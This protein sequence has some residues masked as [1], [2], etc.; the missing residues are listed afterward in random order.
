MYGSNL[1]RGMSK[2]CGCYQSDKAREQHIVHGEYGTP[3]YNI[4]AG[5][6]QRCYYDKH[7]DNIWYSSK[8]ITVCDE[9]RHDFSA[10][11]DWALSSGYER[12]LS[13]DRISNDDGYTPQNC[14]WATSKEQARNRTN[15]LV[16]T[17]NGKTQCLKQWAEELGLK[18]STL[19]YRVRVCGD[20]FEEAI[21][22]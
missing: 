22:K 3:L 18:Y 15:N 12:G 8:K 21:S 4:W 9:W 7:I 19:Y 2:S 20:T 1:V 6:L 17:H 14:R 11:R 5:M 10:F 16:Y 13:I